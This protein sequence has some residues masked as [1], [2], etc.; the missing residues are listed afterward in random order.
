MADLSARV[1]CRKPGSECRG[2]IAMDQHEIGSD[3]IDSHK[4]HLSD[5][6]QIAVKQL[7]ALN[8]PATQLRTAQA[9]AA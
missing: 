4:T 9:G 8:D 6:C 7:A 2:R 1:E 5:I 3:L